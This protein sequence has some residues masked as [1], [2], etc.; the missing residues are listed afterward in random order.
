MIGEKFKEKYFIAGGEHF[1]A[2]P[3]ISL[4]QQELVVSAIKEIL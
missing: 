1:T 2:A 4:E 3:E